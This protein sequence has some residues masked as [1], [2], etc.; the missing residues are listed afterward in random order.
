MRGR[1]K[2]MRFVRFNP[3]INYFKPAGVP[4]RQLSEEILALDEVEAIRLSDL[5]NLDQEKA[6]QQMGISRI[7]YLR[8]LHSAH[9]KIARSLIYGKALRMKGGDIIMPN[10][11]GTGPTG[12]GPMTGRRGMA[13][14]RG[15][16]GTAYCECPNCGEKT[17][18]TR[19]IPCSQSKCPK[20]GTPMRGEFC[21]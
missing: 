20:C 18:H 6:S 7:T 15:E 13:G 3:E 10:F 21:R 17:P 4:L 11:D 9:N 12:Q 8:I 1:P 5:E 16:N 14:R 19:G 2:R